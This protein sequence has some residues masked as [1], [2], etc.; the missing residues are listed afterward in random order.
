[1]KNLFEKT[2]NLAPFFILISLF[3]SVVAFISVKD[4]EYEQYLGLLRTLIWPTIVLMSL[5]FFR[6]V[7]TYLFFSMESFNFFG[8]KGQLR[9]IREIIEERVEDRLSE[10]KEQEKR[11]EELSVVVRRFKKAEESKS[12]AQVELTETKNLVQKVIDMY[13]KLATEHEET[14]KELNEFRRRH[15]ER[16]MRMDYIR[17]RARHAERIHHVEEGSPKDGILNVHNPIRKRRKE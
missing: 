14:V 8:A 4:L 12:G 2:L 10:K 16:E 6:K 3:S 1:M 17:N 7:F 9:D 11:N 15:E 5:L 13:Q